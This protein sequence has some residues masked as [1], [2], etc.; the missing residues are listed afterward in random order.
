V[1]GFEPLASS[2][3]DL[4]WGFGMELCT[5][6]NYAI[7]WEMPAQWTSP[8]RIGA[9]VPTHLSHACSAPHSRHLL[10]VCCPSLTRDSYGTRAVMTPQP[11]KASQGGASGGFRSTVCVELLDW[12]RA[13]ST[14]RPLIL[15]EDRDITEN[16][17]FR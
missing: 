3:R 15:L 9:H 2:V 6:E 13:G 5:I 7:S 11:S 16:R 10:P 4:H 17:P 1:R 8:M 12:L 14:L